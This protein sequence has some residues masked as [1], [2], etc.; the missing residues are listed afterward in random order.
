MTTL[1]DRNRFHGDPKEENFE[2]GRYTLR[3]QTVDDRKHE[4]EVKAKGDTFSLLIEVFDG[5]E[6]TGQTI[7]G[8][9]D[10]AE[11]REILEMVRREI[12]R[13][14]HTSRKPKD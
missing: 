5:D 2:D 13:G 3:Y 14:E 6:L 9:R 8:F 1:R 12:K 4:D 11:H 10:D 7:Y